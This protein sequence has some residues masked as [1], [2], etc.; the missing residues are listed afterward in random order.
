MNLKS[1][2]F[3]CSA[4][5]RSR[6]DAAMLAHPDKSRTA[7]ISSALEAFLAFV[8]QEEIS[9]LNLFQLVERI[10]STGSGCSFSSQ[11]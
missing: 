7:F 3:R 10:D 5:Q 11:A 1:I 8:E 9:T 2:T 4:A 6:L